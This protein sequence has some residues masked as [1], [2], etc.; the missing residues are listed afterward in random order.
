MLSHTDDNDDQDAT[1]NESFF[2]EWERLMSL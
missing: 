2:Q 1:V